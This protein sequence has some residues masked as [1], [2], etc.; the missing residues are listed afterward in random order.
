MTDYMINESIRH[1]QNDCISAAS[2]QATDGKLTFV[3]LLLWFTENIQIS[4]TWLHKQSHMN[5]ESKWHRN[6]SKIMCTLRKKVSRSEGSVQKPQSMKMQLNLLWS[7]KAHRA[8]HVSH[9]WWTQLV[10][11][12]VPSDMWDELCAGRAKELQIEL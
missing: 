7:S 10:N 8:G 6:A 4:M 1:F 11:S 5:T 3:G 9:V 2:F 12:S